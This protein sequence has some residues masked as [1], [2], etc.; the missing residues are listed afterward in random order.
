LLWKEQT[1]KD[2]SMATHDGALAV[3]ARADGFHV[4]GASRVAG[5]D[6]L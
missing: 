1:G 3:A 5:A 2:L 6:R 4:I